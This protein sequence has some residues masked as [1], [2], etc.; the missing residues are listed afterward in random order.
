MQHGLARHIAEVHILHGDVAL[1][2]RVGHGTV[3]L[4]GMFPGPVTGVFG[5]FMD[6]S[7]RIHMGVDQRHIAFILLGLLIHQ[8]E[9]A[10][11]ARQGHDDG[12][13]LVGDLGDGHD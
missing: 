5:A 3:R 13:D 10:L 2:L 11:G 7:V 9:D 12:V 1:Q 6:R 4:V 8:S